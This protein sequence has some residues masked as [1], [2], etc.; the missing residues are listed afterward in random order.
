MRGAHLARVLVGLAVAV[1]ALLGQHSRRKAHGQQRGQAQVPDLDLARVA[2]D[3]DLVAAQVAMNDGRALGV[4][5]VQPQQHLWCV[6]HIA[7]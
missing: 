6:M 5:V 1:A 2:V 3:V 4:Q 7:E